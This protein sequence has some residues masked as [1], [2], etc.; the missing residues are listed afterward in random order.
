MYNYLN[1]LVLNY[2]SFLIKIIKY[3]VFHIICYLL[4]FV[5]NEMYLEIFFCHKNLINIKQ[6]NKKNILL[7]LN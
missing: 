5:E 6:N 4:I 7:F 3:H 2:S 1:I